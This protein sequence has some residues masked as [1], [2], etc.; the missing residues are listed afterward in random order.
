MSTQTT[1]YSTAGSFTY[2]AP[3]TLLNGTV[4]VSVAAPA[5]AGYSASPPH[6]LGGAVQGTISV[7][8]SGTLTCTVGDN[9][10]S[11]YH[12][13]GAGSLGSGDANG[14][15]GGGSSAIVQS[16]TV[17]IEAGGGGGAPGSSGTQSVFGGGG[18][19]TSF[20]GD[21][22]FTN[23]SG[24][25][26]TYSGAGGGGGGHQGNGAA[27]P[28]STGTD[29]GGAGAG[30]AGSVNESPGASGYSIGGGG[31][32]GQSYTAASVASPTFIDN[33]HIGNVG[34]I[35]VTATV[36]DAPLAPTLLSP[37]NGAYLD[38]NAVGVTFKWTYN[39]G[40]DSGSQSYYCLRVSTDGA[41]YQYWNAT[42]G[43]FQS[44]Q[45]WNASS[46]G[47]AVIPAAVLA[48]GHTYTWSVATEESHYNLAGPFA[49]DQ[50]ITATA[51]PTVTV[52]APSGT[53]SSPTPAVTWT[54]TLGS[55]D[56]QTSYR[57][58][59]YTASVA[60]SAGFSP[61]VT[62]PTL[63]SG[64]VSSAATSWTVPSTLAQGSYV[65]YVQ[66]TE[67]GSISSQWASS[68]FTV[69][70]T[71]PS[72]PTV[73]VT[74]GNDAA[75][76]AP[77]VSVLVDGT[78]CFSPGGGITFTNPTATVQRSTDG[79]AT[80]TTVRNGSAVTV[81]TS[82]Y[83][84][85]VVDYE[86][87]FGVVCTYRATLGA[88]TSSPA[89]ATVTSSPASGTVTLTSSR[90]WLTDPLDTTTALALHR[91]GSVGI[92]TSIQAPIS[93]YRTS[94]E[95]LG[96]FYP[97]GRSTAVIQR[98]TKKAPVFA[99]N[100]LLEG[101]EERAT[102]EALVGSDAAARDATLLIRSDMGDSWYVVIGPDIPI[103]VI[104]ATD[105]ITN[106][107]FVVSAATCTTTDTP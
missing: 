28:A 50:A 85:T 21:D 10:S 11:G 38:T 65:A 60:A 82:T 105:R 88:T 36:A 57:V 52:M 5:G 34:S 90:W 9:I 6:G 84:V 78:G 104:R 27:A 61:G 39:P 47:Q 87:P 102:F 40:T 59:I 18:G 96:V 45:V 42:S 56:S 73:T 53:I 46:A 15:N 49:S 23:S 25:T 41:A 1:T 97:F 3:S 2:T 37:A 69:A 16:S 51:M 106:P 43:A 22:G 20:K 4:Q 80:W 66:V 77:N 79:G 95:Q 75:T 64:V 32:G 44:S 30:A 48:D 100:C 94:S 19:T 98:G 91:T 71:G 29:A 8:A 54:E 92:L 26:G 67:T 12:T 33:S 24:G 93:F 70:Y 35:Q 62:T 76:G 14:G 83:Q 13:G 107:L 63:D 99:L 31:A 86:A 103:G 89:G 68:S 58:C 101:Y 72:T 7:A 81:P 74:A 55:G 17:L